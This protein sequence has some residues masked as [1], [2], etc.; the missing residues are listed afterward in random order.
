MEVLEGQENL[1]SVKLG[2]VFAKALVL[3]DVH[4]QIASLHILHDKVETS[5]RLEAGVQCRQEGMALFVGH[6]VNSLFRTST[7]IMNE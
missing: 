1:A 7:G 3:L 5:V 4:H 6:L 2:S